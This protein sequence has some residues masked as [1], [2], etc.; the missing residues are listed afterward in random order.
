MINYP[1]VPGT[2]GLDSARLTGKGIE[3]CPSKVA[4]SGYDWLVFHD[5]NRYV[6]VR[7]LTSFLVER[8]S[9]ALVFLNGCNLF[10]PCCEHDGWFCMS[11]QLSHYKRI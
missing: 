5:S 7:Y 9:H 8:Q 10:A 4:R 3:V 11:E 6:D 1:L 2:E